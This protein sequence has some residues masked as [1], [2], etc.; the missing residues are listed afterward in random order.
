LRDSILHAQIFQEI[1]RGKFSAWLKF[2]REGGDF[3]QE[4]FFMGEFYT[5]E[6][7]NWRGGRFPDKNVH[8]E[9]ISG[10]I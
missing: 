2:F 6:T 1:T 5:G 3:L 8:G 10:M 4:K 7:F 9:E